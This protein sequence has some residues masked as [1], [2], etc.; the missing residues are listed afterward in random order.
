M[1]SKKKNLSTFSPKKDQCEICCQYKVNNLSEEKYQIHI[2][3]K[4]LAREEK[5]KTNEV[6]KLVNVMHF[7]VI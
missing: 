3:R 2:F 5:K 7:L 1:F 4:N 6:Q